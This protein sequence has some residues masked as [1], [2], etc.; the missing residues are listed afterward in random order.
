ME[1]NDS[2]EIPD[3]R[4]TSDI[5]GLPSGS[6]VDNLACLL[7]L[8]KTHRRLKILTSLLQTEYNTANLDR[9]A[10][11]KQQNWQFYIKKKKNHNGIL[12]IFER[13]LN[14]TVIDATNILCATSL[15]IQERLQCRFYVKYQNS[16]VIAHSSNQQQMTQIPP[17]QCMNDVPVK[18]KL[19]SSQILS[20]S[21]H[22]V[23]SHPA[24]T[25]RRKHETRNSETRVSTV[26]L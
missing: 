4:K 25:W 16:P 6:I 2:P 26:I 15:D 1:S 17:C 13:C 20:T 23:Q 3:R 10:S 19:N 12:L 8:P 11:D 24:S 9:S 18:Y 7:V 5:P 14:L 22:S 21:V